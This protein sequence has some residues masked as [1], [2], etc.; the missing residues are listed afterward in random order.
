MNPLT[1][2]DDL[3]CADPRLA[4]RGPRRATT[5]QHARRWRRLHLDRQTRRDRILGVAPEPPHCCDVRIKSRIRL[6]KRS[7]STVS[8]LSIDGRT[9]SLIR[10]LP[11]IL[12]AKPLH[13]STL[14][15]WQRVGPASPSF[16]T[17]PAFSTIDEYGTRRNW[18]MRSHGSSSASVRAT[19]PMPISQRIQVGDQ[20]TLINATGI[21][22]LSGHVGKGQQFDWVFI[23]GCD[24]DNM[25]FFRAHDSPTELEE[26]A[27][28]L[29]VMVSRA[30]HGVILTRSEVVPKADGHDKARNITRFAPPLAA[31]TMHDRAAIV[32]WLK[33]CTMGAV[34][35][36]RATSAGQG[37]RDRTS[38]LRR[39]FPTPLACGV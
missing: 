39:I 22:L 21:H 24:D 34:P 8:S 27:R 30:R 29:G 26:E 5:F 31:A 14:S 1:G 38:S 20:S 7:S 36:P 12:C 33:D 11:D 25:P 32:G 19:I 18:S 17:S 15:T 10:K 9:G 6:L 35:H 28:I 2:G 13:V 4:W 37:Y 3:I 16:V 23:V